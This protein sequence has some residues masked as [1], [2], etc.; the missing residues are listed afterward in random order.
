MQPPQI[1]L[2]KVSA[3]ANAAVA[4]AMAVAKQP[5]TH[6]QFASSLGAAA[7]PPPA[8][9]SKFSDSMFCP[10]TRCL[11]LR[12]FAA[13]PED[14]NPGGLSASAV[15]ARVAAALNQSVGLPPPKKTGLALLMVTEPPSCTLIVHVSP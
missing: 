2:A 3:A 7:P 11:T 15:G 9:K 5:P 14:F 8:R 10:L 12:L 4:A 6:T 13:P 1:D